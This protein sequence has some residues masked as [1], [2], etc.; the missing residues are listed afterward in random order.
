M[1]QGNITKDSFVNV[2]ETRFQCFRKDDR[3]ANE[4][5]KK[6]K[7]WKYCHGGAFHSWDFEE[8]RQQ[9]CLKELF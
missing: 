2:W 4:K 6:C 5:C 8:N 1:I 7:H 9:M 3:T